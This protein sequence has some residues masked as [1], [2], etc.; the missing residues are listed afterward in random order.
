MIQV[1]EPLLTNLEEKRETL[2]GK[3]IYEINTP[4][5]NSLPLHEL[6]KTGGLVDEKISEICCIIH[7]EKNH[8]RIKQVPTTFEDGGQG[9]TY[10]I[11][12]ITDKKTYEE[13]L[14]MSEARYRGIVEDQTEFITR[15]HP[16][17][18]LIFL[19]ESYARYLGENPT[20]LLGRHHIPGIIQDDKVILDQALQTLESEYPVTS[21]ECRISE[22]S[23]NIRWNLWTIRKLVNDDTGACE[24]QG[25]GKDITEKREAAARINQYITQMEFFSRK[26][27]EFIELPPNADIYQ[28]IGAGLDDLL[29]NTIIDINAYDP[30]SKNLILKAI[31]GKRAQEFVD[32]TRVNGCQWEASPS[33]DNVPEVL[34]SGKLFHLPGKLHY[35]SF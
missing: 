15:F 3:Q 16:D 22:T 32:R 20:A 10:I 17:G 26:L 8:F 28:A 35:A 6:N 9:V 27:Q 24:F 21:I 23:G 25:V 5:F 29:P 18:S 31:Y 19:N 34:S 4:F 14:R 30:K 1:N 12:D 11:E 2:L 33:Y 7:G 13:T